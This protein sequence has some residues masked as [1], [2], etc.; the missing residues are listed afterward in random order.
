MRNEQT[1]SV[2]EAMEGG[3]NSEAYLDWEA[4][5]ELYEASDEMDGMHYEAQP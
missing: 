3:F 4:E 1:K 5:Q 2:C